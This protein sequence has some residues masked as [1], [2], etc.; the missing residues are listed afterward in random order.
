MILPVRHHAQRVAEDDDRTRIAPVRLPYE[1]R[2]DHTKVHDERM[3]AVIA[4]AKAHLGT[5]VDY[6]SRLRGEPVAPAQFARL[7][8]FAT[9]VAASYRGP[10]LAYSLE[11]ARDAMSSLAALRAQG[12]VEVLMAAKAMTPG[13]VFDLAA[14]YLSGFDVSNEGE[15]EKLPRVLAGK[16]VFVTA[17]VFPRALS[18]FTSRDNDLVVTLDSLAQYEALAAVEGPVDYCIRLSTSKLLEQDSHFGVPPEAHDLLQR[19]ITC[20]RHRFRGFHCHSGWSTSNTREAY[21]AMA[22][23][24]AAAARRLGVELAYLNLGGGICFL[25]MRELEAM[26]GE[27]KRVLPERTVLFFEPG[28]P[29][30][31]RAG[32]ALGRIEAIV[33]RGD[34]F[35][36]V[37]DLSSEAHLRWTDPMLIVPTAPPGS[38][39]IRVR[40]VGP[41]C[42]ESDVLGVFEVPAATGEMPYRQ[43]DL[44]MFGDVVGYSA[45]WNVGFNGRPPAQ[46]VHFDGPGSP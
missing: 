25:S 15:Y 37:V 41:T 13:P 3:L 32:F 10:M 28:R 1:V 29:L 6:F 18:A 5:E 42:A 17:P 12:G 27:I 39:T 31:E 38:P 40:I 43:G 44:L 33:L 21:V 26:V 46:V 16:T 23:N 11:L 35:D 45:C 4:A 7:H 24:A 14:R 2:A 8:A 20:G 22:R 36:L 30:T 34:L 9:T 19:M